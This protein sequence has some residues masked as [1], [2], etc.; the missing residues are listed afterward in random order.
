MTYTWEEVMLGIDVKREMSEKEKQRQAIADKRTKEEERMAG[1][2][3]GLSLLGAVIGGPLGYHIGK[4]T[5][6]I[7][8]DLWGPG[9]D[10]EEDV[11]D[12]DEGKFHTG[13]A[14]QYKRGKEKEITAQTQGQ[15]IDFATDLASLYI[16]SGG[17]GGDLTT[18]GSGDDA[19]T[20]FGKAEP[21]G[22]LDL[23]GPSIEEAKY[24]GLSLPGGRVLPLARTLPKDQSLY[25][26]WKEGGFKAAKEKVGSTFKSPLALLEEEIS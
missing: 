11:A 4:Q 9:S 14:K 26:L 23:I 6:K 8:A 5:G 16:M 3:L 10:W 2:G 7:G 24:S 12:L 20:V 21:G 17:P 19:W 25:H 22:V 15:V 1:W 13:E 18:F